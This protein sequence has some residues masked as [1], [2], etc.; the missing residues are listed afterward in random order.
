MYSIL[1]KTG[2]N[3]YTYDADEETKVVFAGDLTETKER[4]LELLKE[5]PSSKLVIVHNTTVT[6][7]ITIEDVEQGIK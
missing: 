3:T 5:Y 2:S 7:E 6:D 1:I 4:Y